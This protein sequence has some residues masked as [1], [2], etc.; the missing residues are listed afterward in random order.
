VTEPRLFLE[1]P[2]PSI[3]EAIRFEEWLDQK[4]EEEEKEQKER[5]RVII[6]DI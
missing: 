4:K 2:L 1:I 6:I 3:E 5:T